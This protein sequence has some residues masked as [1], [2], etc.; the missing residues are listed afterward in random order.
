[1]LDSRLSVYPG[2]SH[3]PTTS[4]ACQA[5]SGTRTIPV[6]VRASVDHFQNR[7]DFRLVLCNNQSR[8]DISP[9]W[10]HIIILPFHLILCP[11]R[12]DNQYQSCV[13]EENGAIENRIEIQ[14]RY[15]G[16]LPNWWRIQL[17]GKLINWAMV[18][19]RIVMERKSGEAH[20]AIDRS[21]GSVK[22][23]RSLPARF[24]D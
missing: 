11:S 8:A 13:S 19:K 12:L 1:M 15:C 14:N 16:S 18:G 7:K 3:L 6:L 10:P 17:V 4:M 22:M 9:P 23:G 2:T 5:V 21:D 24:S 20:V